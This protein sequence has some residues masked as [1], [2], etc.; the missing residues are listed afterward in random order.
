MTEPTDP[1]APGDSADT[2]AALGEKA[3]TGVVPPER[4]EG[5]ATPRRP[6]PS[7]A[8]ATRARRIGGRPSPAPKALSQTKAGSEPSTSR[9]QDGTGPAQR[10]KRAGVSG[11]RATGTTERSPQPRARR[12]SVAKRPG[13]ADE[14]RLAGTKARSTGTG[15]PRRRLGWLRWIPAVITALAAAVML[16]ANLWDLPGALAGKPA[17]HSTKTRQEVLAAAKTCGA[18]IVSYDYRQLPA[19]EKAGQACIT[20]KFKDD[21]T[22]AMQTTVKTLAP[23]TKTVQVFQ[24]AKAGVERVSPDGKQWVV[25]LYGQQQV[26][27]TSTAKNKPRLD[28]LNVEATLNQVD[29]KW[30]VSSIH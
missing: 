26:T 5:A 19:S 29:G 18:A 13:R 20:G 8:A 25:L 12:V 16:I 11:V 3:D 4:A 7:A 6:S 15:T 23:Q 1:A 21:Y 30:L 22:K 10:T 24:I 9:D 2:G 27:S 28:I 17:D 14:D